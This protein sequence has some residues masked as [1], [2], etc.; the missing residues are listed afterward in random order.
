MREKQKMI[1]KR[2]S[3]PEQRKQKRDQRIGPSLP[4]DEK[5]ETEKSNRV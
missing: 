4:F 5:E 1:D 2:H 3:S